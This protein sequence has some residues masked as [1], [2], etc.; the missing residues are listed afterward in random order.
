MA[1]MDMGTSGFKKEPNVVPMIDI[2]LVLLIIFMMQIPLQ[3][4]VMDVQ[5]PPEQQVEKEVA[6][7]SDHRLLAL[8]L[9]LERR[10]LLRQLGQP[11]VIGRRDDQP[12]RDR[13]DA[14]GHD[15]R[16]DES[17]RRAARPIRP[18]G[19][20]RPHHGL[21][22]ASLGVDARHQRGLDRGRRDVGGFRGEPGDRALEIAK[23][24][25]RLGVAR[26]EERFEA[27][28]VLRVERSQR[29]ARGQLGDLVPVHGSIFSIMAP[30]A[31]LP[32]SG[33]AAAR[34]PAAP[35]S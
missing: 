13:G 23:R 33:S 20:Q 35:G 4:K 34:V 14:G 3:R 9:L 19:G 31:P 26:G 22:R 10:R 8:G 15:P 32:S 17:P 27:R 16:E 6:E 5:V 11:P 25:G 18:D 30:L 21:A 29:V 1:G 28:A 7:Q 24:G 2:L 12:D